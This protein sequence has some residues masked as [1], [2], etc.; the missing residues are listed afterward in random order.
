MKTKPDIRL[1]AIDLDG[2]LLDQN[3]KIS[4][5][6]KVA[7]AAAKDQGVL[8]VLTTG[9]PYPGMVGYLEECHLM[10]EGDY[11][12][13]YNGAMV[14]KTASQEILRKHTF[15]KEEIQST[16]D[17]LADLKLPLSAI[18]MDTIYES[19]P[20]QGKPSSYRD[21]QP[22]LPVVENI[23]VK[24]LEDITK[25]VSA[26]PQAEI[27]RAL[28]QIPQAYQ[29]HFTIVRSR[30]NLVE[31]LAK[32]VD[33]ASGLDMLAQELQ[34]K[35]SQMMAIGDM[36]NDASMLTYAGIGVAMGNAPEAIQEISDYVTKSNQD[37]GVAH[38]IQKFVLKWKQA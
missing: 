19:K 13:T 9:R 38:A 28:A 34:I 27:D 2:T 33:K 11:C 31:I 32:G 37:H 29:D 26:R 1:I 3:R 10:E 15:S 6:N 7:I 8:P 36:G 12:I 18:G 35:P 20:P 23:A 24:D 4:Q 14:Q 25:I 16:A 22:L 30:P 5:E 17:L 21:M